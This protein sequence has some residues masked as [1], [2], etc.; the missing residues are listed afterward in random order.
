M[1]ALVKSVTIIPTGPAALLGSFKIDAT[2]SMSRSYPG[3]V[4][5]HPLQSGLEGISD[6]VQID[7]D[8]IN[9][10]GILTDTPLS[11][12]NVITVPGRAAKMVDLLEKMRATRQ[13]FAVLTSWTGMLSSRW[14]SSF[15]VSRSTST[16]GALDISM[17]IE[18]LRVVSTMLVPAQ[19]DADIASLGMS[20]VSVGPI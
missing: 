20:T 10:V 12:L 1:I 17:T 13:R 15:D 2:T 7:P 9:I 18:K 3:S 6:A 5:R 8:V 16:G 14:V 11:F 19:L 4:S